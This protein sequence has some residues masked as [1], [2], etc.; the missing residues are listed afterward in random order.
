M[1]KGSTVK[2]SAVAASLFSLGCLLEDCWKG[3]EWSQMLSFAQV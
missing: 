3:S 1:I 2:Q